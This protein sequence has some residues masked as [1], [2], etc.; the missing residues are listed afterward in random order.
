MGCVID[1]LLAV[2]ATSLLHSFLFQVNPLD[3]A[4]IVLA[5]ISIFSAGACGFCY[6]HPSCRFR[7]PYAGAAR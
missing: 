2:F 1:T 7:R 4:A 3:P 5:A 6:S